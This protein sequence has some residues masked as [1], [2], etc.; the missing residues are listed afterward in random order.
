MA[1][2]AF[3]GTWNSAKDNEDAQYHN[4]NVVRFYDAYRRHSNT[5]DQDFYVAGVGTRAGGIGAALGGAFGLG[6]LPRLNEAYDRLCTNWAAGDHLI[7]IVG[8]SRGAATTLDFCNI[9][10]SRGIRR[11]ASE[12]VVEPNPE[13]RFLGVWDVVGAFGLA[14]LGNV[15][16]DLF[17]HLELPKSRLRYCFHALAL[18]ERRPSFLPTRLPGAYEVWFRGVHSDIGGGNGNLGLNDITLKW[19]LSKAKAAGLPIADEDIAALKPPDPAVAP[20]PAL[21]LPFNLRVVSA[22]DRRHHTANPDAPWMSAP[23]TCPIETIADE[24]TAAELG[25]KGIETMPIEQRRRVL[26]LWETAQAVAKEQD[27]S[28]NELHDALLTLFQGRVGLITNDAQLAQGQQA[29]ARLLATA[30]QGASARGYHNNVP[31]FFLTEALFKM[32]RVF[33][34]TD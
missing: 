14:F 13:I 25:A 15:A 16:L 17:H 23:D 4:T 26:A 34:L 27:V 33:P 24:Q 6:E 29:A 1:L 3:D 20:Q 18:D 2:Y 30:I 7:D 28:I 8:F 10:Q 19:M 12:D 21:T 31:E 9:I 11:P 5:K 22:V 32:P